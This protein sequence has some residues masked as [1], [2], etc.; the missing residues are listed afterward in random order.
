MV[1]SLIQPLNTTETDISDTGNIAARQFCVE[2]EGL[3]AEDTLL[4]QNRYIQTESKEGVCHDHPPKSR[5]LNKSSERL[6]NLE[7][8]K[9]HIE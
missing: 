2:Y 6:Q 1:N 3:T 4:H 7:T 5:K 9:I 8:S